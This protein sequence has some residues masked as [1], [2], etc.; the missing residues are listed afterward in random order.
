MQ[1]I[2]HNELD[3]ITRRSAVQVCSSVRVNSC[4]YSETEM[5][6]YNRERT[7]LAGAQQQQSGAFYCPPGE[8][9]LLQPF[10]YRSSFLKR[11]VYTKGSSISS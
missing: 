4:R 11:K 5:C 1:C 9:V 10:S 2:N 8:I 6:I 7:A 3:F